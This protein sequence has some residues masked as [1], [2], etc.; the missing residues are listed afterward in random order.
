MTSNTLEILSNEMADAVAAAADSVVQVRG[1]RGGVSGVAYSDSTVVTSARALGREDRTQVTTADGRSAAAELTG[2]DPASGLAVLRVEGLTLKPARLSAATPR[3]GQ[4]ALAIGRSWSN[5][6]TASAG[7]VA[8]IGRAAE[9]RAGLR[10]QPDHP[11][12]R[13]VTRRLRRRRCR[14]RE[15]RGDRDRTVAGRMRGLAVTVPAGIAWQGA[16]HVLEHGR[17]KVGYLGLS[18]QTVALPNG[19]ASAAAP[20]CSSRASPRAGPPILPVC[21]SATWSSG[22]T[23]SRCGRSTTSWRC[24]PATAFGRTVPLHLLRGGAALD[25]VTVAERRAS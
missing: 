10:A 5:A 6:L 20:A 4:I 7:I 1:R 9:D 14:R 23:T 17:P 11:Y 22:W 15:R 12:H 19:S 24:S 3:V 2:W 16:A 21:S 13:A 25:V 18:G 8:V